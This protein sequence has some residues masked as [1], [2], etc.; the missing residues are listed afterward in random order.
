MAGEDVEARI[1]DVI[2]DH[3]VT[4]TTTPADLPLALQGVPSPGGASYLELTHMPNTVDQIFLGTAGE[5]RHRGMVQIDVKM[6]ENTALN[7]PLLIAGQVAGHFRRGLDLAG[8]G[9]L[10]V[11]IYRPPVIGPSL[12]DRPHLKVPV[13]IYYQAYVPNPS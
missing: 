10:I 11:T 13:T 1:Y 2:V 8:T 3:M 5:N 6:P 9:G 7:D 4:L 12:Q